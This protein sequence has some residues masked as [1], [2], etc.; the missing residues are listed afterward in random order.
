MSFNVSTRLKP[1]LS[2]QTIAS[3]S[4]ILWDEFECVAVVFI[5]RQNLLV[6]N[7]DYHFK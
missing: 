5:K 4:S 6:R 7:A 1:S 3:S 2:E